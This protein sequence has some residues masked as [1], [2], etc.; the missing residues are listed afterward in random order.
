[1][2][3]GRTSIYFQRF[4]KDANQIGTETRVNENEYILNHNPAIA[5][6]SSGNFTIVWMN[7]GYENPPINYSIY[8]QRYDN[9]GN[10]LGSNFIVNP[11][12]AFIEEQKFPAIAMNDNGNFVVTWQGGDPHGSCSNIFAQR[13]D[14]NGNFIGNEFYVTSYTYGCQYKPSISFSNSGTFVITWFGDIKNGNSTY[15]I[16]ARRFDWISGNPLDANNLKVNTYTEGNQENPTIAIGCLGNFV[17]AWE[18]EEQD[19]SGKGIFFQMYDYYG[20]KIGIETQANTFTEGDQSWSAISMDGSGNF[21]I[22]WQSYMQDDSNYAV[23]AQKFD[24]SGNKIDAEYIVNSFT[25]DEQSYP[26]IDINTCGNYVIAWQCWFG[27][28]G[29]AFD[30]YAKYHNDPFCPLP[31]AITL[32]TF[33]AKA[34]DDKIILSW[35]TGTEIDNLGFYLVKSENIDSGYILLNKEII[36]VMGTPYSG[37]S[38]QYVDE[39]VKAGSVYYYWLADVDV[40]GKYEI[41]G[42]VK[43]ITNLATITESIGLK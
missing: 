36:P 29:Y 27:P 35:Q 43:V 8:A 20:N 16:S 26:S 31:C 10:P 25:D 22:A 24:S 21:I 1:Y 40:F 33:T 15:E 13:F 19:N 23:I 38:Y 37:Y 39:N 11:E 3:D 42:P 32:E 6:D 12:T 30:I 17:I 2:V 4:D 14:K 9:N 18:S 5:I 34:I 7:H 28:E 41:H